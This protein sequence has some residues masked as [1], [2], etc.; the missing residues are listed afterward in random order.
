MKLSRIMWLHLA[1]LLGMPSAPAQVAIVHGARLAATGPGAARAVGAAM[2]RTERF[3]AAAGV[4]A[5]RLEDDRL[6]PATLAP[7]RAL[8][9]PL[10]R[11]DAA[12]LPAIAA[13]I[14]R[15]GGL[16]VFAPEGPPEF[17]ALLGLAPEEP[18]RAPGPF[19]GIALDPGNPPAAPGLPAW[20][21]LPARAARRLAPLDG[22]RVLGWW[23]RSSAERAGAGGAAVPPATAPAAAAAVAATWGPGGVA[24]AEPLTD[25]EVDARGWFLR[26]LLARWDPA[27]A[28]GAVPALRRQV[29]D[30]LAAVARDAAERTGR[31]GDERERGAPPSR[32][33][34]EERARV[35]A[36]LATPV[37]SPDDAAAQHAALSACQGTV[38]RLRRLGFAMLPSPAGE[39]RAVWIHTYSPTDWDVV[40]RKLRDHGFNAIFVRVGRGGNVIYPS[41]VLPRDAWANGPGDELK[42]AVD[43]AHRYGIAFYAWRVNYDMR[44]APR[45]YFARMAA[46]DRLVR[47]PQGKQGISANPADPRNADLELRAMLEVVDRYD[48]DGVQFDYIRY[49]DEPSFDFDYGPVS[50]RE[51]ERATGRP[52]ADWPADVISGPRKSEYEAWEVSN[53]DR[54]VERVSQA[55]KRRKPWVQVSAAV[56][57]NHRRYRPILKQD[58][59]RWVERGWLDF[60][61]PMDYTAEPETLAG[62]V[63]AQVAATRGRAP[64]VAGIGNWLLQ[65]PEELLRQVTAARAAG[66]AGFA[67][68]AYNADQIDEH[69]EALRAGA[70]SRSTHPALPAPFFRLELPEGVTRKDAPLAVTAGR[71]VTIR[72]EVAGTPREARQ[73]GG[74]PRLSGRSSRADRLRDGAKP[75][76]R[77]TPLFAGALRGHDA[78]HPRAEDAL[79]SGIRSSGL[80][81]PHLLS[82]G[83]ARLETP[84][85]R[86]LAVLGPVSGARVGER[87]WRV[88]APEGLWRPVVRGIGVDAH[89]RAVNLLAAGPVAEGVDTPTMSA[90]RERDRPPLST[91]S[92]L[93]VGVYAGGLAAEALQSALADLPGIR[94]VLLYHLEPAFLAPADVLLL[95]QLTDLADLTPAAVQALRAWTA[96]GGRLILT[97]DA[98]GARWHPRLFPEVGIGGTLKPGRAMALAADVGTLHAGTPFDAGYDDYI[99]LSPTPQARVLVREASESGAPVVIAGDFGRGEVILNGM[100]PGYGPTPLAGIERE[101]LRALVGRPPRAPAARLERVGARQRP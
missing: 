53:V 60:V 3:L 11:L 69:L 2:A 30:T 33:L 74:V 65:T 97:H 86:L 22:T 82:R 88:S 76:K 90:L 28:S 12:D 8:V 84:D 72:L 16:V 59:L 23:S 46:E 73:T 42:R 34:Q 24:V 51:F 81:D 49:P 38:T 41:A 31:T 54:L 57:R 21:P 96:A 87:R 25:G 4:S 64:V 6:T 35:S 100:L 70:T 71:L 36:L 94:T 89:G 98:V 78:A 50:R 29:T 62:T 47:D 19:T 66:A 32:A 14:G 39:L 9:L 63:A 58:W 55:V 93:L 44:S 56:W 95:P 18:E 10:N 83:E 79:R 61:V 67:L 20:L 40:M 27:L 45:D 75:L 5:A 92:S 91:G 52:I 17:R 7:F 77:G 26:A 80:L 101:L 85:G 37:P 1:L 43:T 13:F 99:P 68:F 48:V 15:G